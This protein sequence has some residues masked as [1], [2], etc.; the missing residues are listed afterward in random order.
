MVET[1]G[2]V[3]DSRVWAGRGRLAQIGWQA[4]LD[5]QDRLLSPFEDKCVLQEI[6]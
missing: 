5:L 2:F 1:E 3:E 4:V 6:C